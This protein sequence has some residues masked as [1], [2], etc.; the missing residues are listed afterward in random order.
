MS[1]TEALRAAAENALDV[2]DEARSYTN[3]ESWSPSMTEE[4][5]RA[6]CLLRAALAA[7]QAPAPAASGEPMAYLVRDVNGKRGTGMLVRACNI[8]SYQR[9][10]LER[11]P[12]YTAH[13]APALVPL[14]EAQIATMRDAAADQGLT[15]IAPSLHLARAVEAWH[16]ITA[17][18]APDAQKG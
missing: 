3:S 15:G 13:P 9:A 7:Q 18:G 2:L 14:T 4:C 11:E 5:E 12:L 1:N 10:T 8:G 6:M 16:G 17:P